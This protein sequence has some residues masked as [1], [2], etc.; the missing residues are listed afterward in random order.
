VVVKFFHV[1]RDVPDEKEE[2]NV[3][4]RQCDDDDDDRGGR[5][6]VVVVAGRMRIIMMGAGG[7]ATAAGTVARC[8]VVSERTT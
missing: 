5:T 8:T 2:D 7:A 1:G 3:H 4:P 6:M